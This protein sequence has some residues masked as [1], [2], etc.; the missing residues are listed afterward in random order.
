MY[1]QPVPQP[2]DE[3]SWSGA[4]GGYE[5]G[6]AGP[7][8]ESDQLADAIARRLQARGPSNFQSP[9][10]MQFGRPTGITS[11]Q[12]LALAIVSVAMLVPLSGII[13]P[14]LGSV[15]GPFTALIGFGIVCAAILGVNIAFNMNR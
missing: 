7:G 12:R 2:Q 14:I 11:G 15:G 8:Q 5:A 4:A 13:L 9:V 3:R 6:Y 1:Q 10:G